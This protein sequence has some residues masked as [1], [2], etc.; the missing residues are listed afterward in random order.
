[1]EEYD[2]DRHAGISFKRSSF[3]LPGMSISI[4]SPLDC[5]GLHS[6]IDSL[7]GEPQRAWR[8]IFDPPG[9]KQAFA[10]TI[11]EKSNDH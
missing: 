4:R 3:E 6:P 8:P 7:K 10:Q 9:D 5:G 1:M 11:L 2:V